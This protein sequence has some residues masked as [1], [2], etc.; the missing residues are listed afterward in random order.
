MHVRRRRVALLPSSLPWG[1]CAC[2]RLPLMAGQ[3]CGPADIQV[4]LSINIYGQVRGL[5][6]RPVQGAE[7]AS[8]ATCVEI[9]SYATV[10]VV[11]DAGL[12]QVSTSSTPD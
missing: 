1:V 9:G 2:Q 11:G 7:P 8:F 10:G 3:L 4:R 12:K 6:A 5:S